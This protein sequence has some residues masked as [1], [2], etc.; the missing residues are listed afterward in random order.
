MTINKIKSI[1]LS[2]TVLLSSVYL[3]A[4]D[5][6]SN[7]DIFKGLQRGERITI[8]LND[9]LAFTGIIKSII[10]NKIEIDISYDEPILRGSI[11]FNS[12]D[13]KS[14]KSRFSISEAEKEKIISTKEKTLSEQNQS[15]QLPVPNTPARLDT[16]SGGDEINN[17]KPVTDTTQTKI[18]EEDENTKKSKLLDLLK[19]FPPGEIWNTKNCEIISA[20]NAFLRTAEENDFLEQYNLWLQALELKEKMDRSDLFQKFLPKNGWGDDKYQELITKYIRLK[21]GLTSEEQEFVVNF[22][23]WKQARIEYE[24]EKKK[25]EEEQKKTDT[26]INPSPSNPDE[27]T[28]PSEQ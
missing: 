5:K 12:K 26:E 14:I 15:R 28:P 11:S 19:Q 16:R 3:L 6:N 7:K 17:E 27:E 2:L 9:E 18:D 24:E 20:K 10:N 8:I 21:V 1:I 13:I 23:V 4:D 22:G 25:Q